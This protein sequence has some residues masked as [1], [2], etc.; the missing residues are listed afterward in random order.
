MA[1]KRSANFGTYFFIGF[2]GFLIGSVI[3]QTLIN[4][5]QS[6][7]ITK[8]IN[9]NGIAGRFYV[10]AG[11]IFN[12]NLFAVIGILLAIYIYRRI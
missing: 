3:G 6:P 2:I 7:L 9:L 8:I 11:Y 1:V 10:Y 12:I 5:I 4:I